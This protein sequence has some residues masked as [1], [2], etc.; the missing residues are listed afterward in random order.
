MPSSFTETHY[1][2]LKGNISLYK[3]SLNDQKAF[4]KLLLLRNDIT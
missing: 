4:D 3:P 2:E 1:E